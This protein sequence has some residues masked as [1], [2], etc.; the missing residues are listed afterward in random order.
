VAWSFVDALAAAT[1]LWLFLPAGAEIALHI[2]FPL[3]L[4]AL[5]TS[6]L[7]NTPGGVGPFELILLGSFPHIPPDA[8]VQS[9]IAFRL[10][11]Y[12]MPATLGMVRLLWP[13]P[14]IHEGLVERLPNGALD[15]ARR[16]EVGVIQQ[17]GGEIVA[18]S[19][20]SA[21]LWSIPQTV[22]ALF[23]PAQGSMTACMRT[24]DRAARRTCK[25][26]LI[27]K[28]SARGAAVARL[29]GWSVVK[30]AE[31]AIIDPISFSLDGSAKR[32]LRRKMRAASKAGVVVRVHKTPPFAALEQINR[33]WCRTKGGARAG[34]M[35][36]YT[37]DYLRGKWLAVAY[38]GD[39]PVAFVSFFRSTQ[40][41]SL[42][43][44]RHAQ[45][46]PNG[47][48]HVLVARAIQDARA[49]GVPSL[50]LASVPSFCSKQE[51]LQPL[52]RWIERRGGH[53]GLHQ[54]KSAFAPRW[55]PRF[56]AAPNVFQLGIGLAD[57]TREI[58]HPD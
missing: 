56:A 43:L 31:D 45:E 46:A 20:G 51:G 10:V 54:F 18:T 26:V 9:I 6:L 2:L 53:A 52:I 21:A 29:Q 5:L 25:T 42:D 15:N 4:M 40:E 27:Y 33:D 39:N 13:F 11:Y 36:R 37:N 24:L 44:M 47:T 30:V 3:Y 57:V 49:T 48:M 12:A 7:S 1:A 28:C 34:S 38:V 22:V 50:S 19:D 35:G 58:H 16:S 17:N 55:A 23:C 32:T 14:E 8:L 41:W